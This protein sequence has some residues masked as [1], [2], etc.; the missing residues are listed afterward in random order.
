MRAAAVAAG[1]ML[2]TACAP[3]WRSLEDQA[4]EPAREISEAFLYEMFAGDVEAALALMHPDLDPDEAR[5]SL[6][7]LAALAAT[8]PSRTRRF[9][10]YVWIVHEAA[11]QQICS[12]EIDLA[13]GYLVVAIA[14][15]VADGQLKIAGFQLDRF[16]ESPIDRHRFGLAHRSPT[17]YLF[18]TLAIA[19]PLFCVACLVICWRQNHPLRLLWLL[20]ILVAYPV[21]QLNWTTAEVTPLWLQVNVL[22]SS[23]EQTGRLRP[24]LLDVGLPIGALA[25]LIFARPFRT[26]A[27]ESGE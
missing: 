11:S 19:F 23:F 17:H 14:I 6:E 12:Y 27:A 24:L 8:S 20:A 2:L 5:Q 21:L 7:R 26:S 16:A 22:G 10:S 1:V 25:F 15:E 3:G 4:P 9:A 13:D 18:F